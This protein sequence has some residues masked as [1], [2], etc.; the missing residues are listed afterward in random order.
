MRKKLIL[1][2]SLIVLLAAIGA[3]AYFVPEKQTVKAAPACRPVNPDGSIW[4]SVR[5]VAAGN[6]YYTDGRVT[7]WNK[8]IDF[9]IEH[10][11]V[12]TQ[13]FQRSYFV[14][15]R[16]PYTK[17]TFYDTYRETAN[18]RS[19]PDQM[20]GLLQQKLG[21]QFENMFLH[22][23][24][25][26]Q[27][28]IGN[29]TRTIPGYNTLPADQ[30]HKS[31][32]PLDWGNDSTDTEFYPNGRYWYVYPGL[33]IYKQAKADIIYGIF[34]DNLVPDP[35][36]PD[37]T[38]D[39][40]DG[41]MV[42]NMGKNPFVDGLQNPP[43]VP[44][45]TGA[46]REYSGRLLSDNTVKDDFY[47]EVATD[48][49]YIHDYV[50]TNLAQRGRTLKIGFIANAGPPAYWYDGLWNGFDAFGREL[51]FEPGSDGQQVIGC[52]NQAIEATQRGKATH[53]HISNRTDLDPERSKIAA[54]ADYYL[55]KSN[56]VYLFYGWVTW[57]GDW[58]KAIEYDIGQPKVGIGKTD[59]SYYVLK[60]INDPDCTQHD[61]YDIAKFYTREYDKALVLSVPKP[62]W[63][64]GYNTSYTANLPSYDK[65]GG[66]TSNRYQKLNSDGTI[67]PNI[68]TSITLKNAEGAILVKTDVVQ[69]A[70]T[71]Q[72]TADK[73][74]VT[75]GKNPPDTITYTINYNVTA[76]ANNVVITDPIPAGTSNPTEISNGGTVSGG[77]ITWNLGNLA[78]GASGSVTF[79]VTVN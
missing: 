31:R 6:L 63:D 57:S 34:R 46:L 16:C 27:V 37:V 47:N 59:D 22:F 61:P 39:D 30:K 69:S 2:G 25:T 74:S 1:I 42:D 54:L 7:D 40:Y 10:F 45:G 64:C 73:T 17:I 66:Q 35:D 44:T 32:V 67:D 50:D 49:T 12:V 65:G 13:P 60:Q 5:T 14:Q 79:K 23:N 21:S 55:A 24:E 70:I 3:V 75:S 33:S 48:A 11:E 53:L 18:P 4:P 28:T 38:G 9:W 52:I 26:T 41:V 20:Y 77:V 51:C 8:E 62:H 76:T 58:F 29:E 15:N 43:Y 36:Y 71:L 56:L 19:K 78:A 72:K 68:I